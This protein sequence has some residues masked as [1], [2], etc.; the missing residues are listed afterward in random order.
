MYKALK[1]FGSLSGTYTD[2]SS[3][4]PNEPYKA[5][6]EL[7]LGE[8]T[9]NSQWI[10]FQISMYTGTQDSVFPGTSNC[11]QQAYVGAY[12]GGSIPFVVING[13]YVH[14]SASL[15]NP[16]LLSNYAYTG[17][18]TVLQQVDSESGPAWSA[19]SAQAWW[20]MAIMAKSAGATPS[21]L[22]SQPYY[23]SW[24][25][26]DQSNVASDLAQL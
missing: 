9:L 2:Y 21:N 3:T 12:S 13:Q 23:A 1:S 19:V 5:T 7:V 20:M 24:T 16:S 6:P 26:A 4:A 8:A 22:A 10:S 14:A 11:Y 15:V 18:N 17:A 25:S